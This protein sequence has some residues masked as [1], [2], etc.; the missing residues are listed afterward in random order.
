MERPPFEIH[1]I[2]MGGWLRVCMGRGEPAGELAVYLSHAL[3]GWFRANPQ[4]RLR[5]VVPISRDGDTMELH[6]WYDQILFTDISRHANA[7]E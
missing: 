1:T 2:D 4:F 6:A 7:S 5:F 3:T